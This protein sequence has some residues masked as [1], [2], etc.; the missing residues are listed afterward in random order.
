MLERLSAK[1]GEC[2]G[3]AEGCAE[4]FRA[5]LNPATQ[6]DLIEMERLWLPQ[7]AAGEARSPRL[8]IKAAPATGTIS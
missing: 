7:V 4:R 1:A 6:R 8:H 2:F 3:R 5:E